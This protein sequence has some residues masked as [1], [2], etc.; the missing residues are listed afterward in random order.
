ML[1]VPKTP[2]RY[3]GVVSAEFENGNL[4]RLFRNDNTFDPDMVQLLERLFAAVSEVYP[5][6]G[7][8]GLLKVAEFYF[9]PGSVKAFMHA[10]T[11]AGI[12]SDADA[13]KVYKYRAVCGVID[14]LY[15][16][17]DSPDKGL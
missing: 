15:T 5:D 1:F 2:D 7:N 12:R 17:V 14:M 16:L 8:S 11:N 9:V 4:I 6:S 10:L 13:C 3:D